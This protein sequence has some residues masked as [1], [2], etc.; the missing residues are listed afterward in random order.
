M[1]TAPWRLSVFHSHHF[2]AVKIGLRL[3]TW[4]KVVYTWQSMS[5]ESPFSTFPSIA[6]LHLSLWDA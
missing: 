2:E 6:L 1:L 5:T 4:S 3:A